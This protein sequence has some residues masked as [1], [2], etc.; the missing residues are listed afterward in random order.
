MTNPE[1][2]T[3]NPE[4]GTLSP[5]PTRDLTPAY[6]RVVVVEAVILALLWYFGRAF[7]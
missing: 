4:P 2:G 7:S 1:R 3:K 5:E 6:I